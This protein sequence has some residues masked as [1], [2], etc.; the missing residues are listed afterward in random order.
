MSAGR[1]SD[2]ARIWGFGPPVTE[3]PLGVSFDA[4]P[5]DCS[6]L[7]G[8][9]GGGWFRSIAVR[10]CPVHPFESEPSA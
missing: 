1:M 4:I 9:L 3:V 7:W 5:D 10:D 8:E 6:C 2:R